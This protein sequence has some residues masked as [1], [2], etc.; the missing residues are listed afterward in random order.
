MGYKNQCT[1]FPWWVQEL[2]IHLAMQ[3]TQV[4]SWAQEDST[5]TEQ[6]RPHKTATDAGTT[7]SPCSATGE[8]TEITSSRPTT[9]EEAPLA[10]TRKAQVQQQRPSTVKNKNKSFLKKSMYRNA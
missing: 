2:K 10:T 4:R 9:R 7:W 8:A 6:L 3:G 5:C 1:R